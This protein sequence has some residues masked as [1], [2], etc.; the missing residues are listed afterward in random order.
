MRG[1]SRYRVSNLRTTRHHISYP[2]LY[3]VSH[4]SMFAFL[5]LQYINCKLN[6]LATFTRYSGQMAAQSSQLFPKMPKVGGWER[7]KELNV[8]STRKNRAAARKFSYGVNR[9]P[10]SWLCFFH[11]ISHSQ[12]KFNKSLYAAWLTLLMRKSWKTRAY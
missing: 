1:K 8:V 9:P 5:K 2:S 11:A 10:L 3:Q 6:D 12:A 7:P 4:N